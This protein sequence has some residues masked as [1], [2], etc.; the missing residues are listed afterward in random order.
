MTHKVPKISENDLKEMVNCIEGSETSADR[1]NKVDK[2]KLVG[3]PGF[4]PE[5]GY[6]SVRGT[7]SRESKSQSLDQA[8]RRPLFCEN[9]ETTRYCNLVS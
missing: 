5:S 1:G 2:V 3:P 4:E 6:A 8:S 7:L 9:R